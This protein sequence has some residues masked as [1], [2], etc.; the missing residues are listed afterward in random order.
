MDTLFWIQYNPKITVDHTTKKYYGKYLYKLVVYAPA[1]RLIDS[2]PR[3][4]ID[5]ALERRRAIYSQISQNTWWGARQNRDLDHADIELLEILRG[6]R[7]ARPIGI[8]LRVEEPRVQI[9]AETEQQLEDLVVAHF[10]PKFSNCVETIAGPADSQA[11]AVLNSGALIRKKEAGYRYKVILRDGRYGTD[12]K[13]SILQY[14][15]NLGE[16]QIFLPK[17]AFDML[18]KSTSYV[19]NLYFLANDPQMTSFLSLIQPGIVSN[20]HELIVLPNK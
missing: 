10:G 7:L 13:Q 18:S 11:E 17:S 12:V 6:L 4:S 3:E 5:Q 2:K 9:Y 16:D 19:W 20:I 1:S 8:K 14:L 15:L